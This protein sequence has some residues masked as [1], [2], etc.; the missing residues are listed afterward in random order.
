MTGP[1]MGDYD[2]ERVAWSEHPTVRMP[3]ATRRLD[4]PSGASPQGAR[5]S[6]RLSW[7]SSRL[8]SRRAPWVAALLIALLA[9]VV[10]VPVLIFSAPGQENSPLVAGSH[11]GIPYLPPRGAT[12]DELDGMAGLRQGA[13]LAYANTLIASMSLDQELG[14][15]TMVGVLGPSLTPD[16]IAW[17]R[18]LQ[19][20]SVILYNGN[21]Q[22]LAQTQA[23]I[24]QLQAN[25]RVPMF[26]M[27]D[28][29]GGLVDR[30]ANLDG[31][32]PSATQLGA[33]GDANAARQQG[34]YDAAHMAQAGV[35]VNLAPVVDVPSVPGGEGAL[36][37]RTFSTSPQVVT[38]MAGAYLSGLQS[39]GKVAGVLKHFPGLGTA[40][41]DPHKALPTVTQTQAQFEATDWAPYKALLASGQV[42]MIMTSHIL[43]PALDP[44]YPATISSAI[45]TGILRDK[46]GFQGI[47]ITDDVF[48]GAMRLN[49]PMD[50]VF[51]RAVLAGNDII[52]CTWGTDESSYYL[53]TIETDVANGSITK[54]RIDESVRRVLLEKMALGLPMPRLGT[55]AADHVTVAA[56]PLRGATV[57]TI[58]STA[59]DA[60]GDK[61]IG[62][63][64]HGDGLVLRWCRRRT[65]GTAVLLCGL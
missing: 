43:A 21:M 44:T 12:T 53:T 36:Y 17:I 40:A 50:E 48:M 64:H 14:Q 37:D 57:P 55:P 65:G 58:P 20:G 46:L 47:I 62:T 28:Q 1:G 33:T 56:P 52:C 18:Q 59:G 31:P 25:V 45:T 24:S 42:H 60:Q 19:P 26:V 51:T 4:A 22:S 39:S 30:M 6:W 3:S 41:T 29:E 10:L 16:D 9:V 8:A 2:R 27:V 54:A 38:T 32:A 7:S 61:A 63:R 13:R 49:F 23:L 5:A 35:N 34:A 11:V 15:L